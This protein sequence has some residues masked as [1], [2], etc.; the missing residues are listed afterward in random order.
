M[1]SYHKGP[2]RV[3]ESFLVNI[4]KKRKSYPRFQHPGIEFIYMLSGR[5]QYRFGDKTFLVEPGDAFTFSGNILH[6][7]EQLLDD[8]IQFITM[9]VYAE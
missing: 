8:H 1:L 3:F 4:D 7:P 2:R 6:A 5:M 9:I